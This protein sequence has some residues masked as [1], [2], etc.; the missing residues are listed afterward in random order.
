MTV[1]LSDKIPVTKRSGDQM[2]QNISEY[3]RGQEPME[4]LKKLVSID[5]RGPSGNEMDMIAFIMEYLK[6]EEGRYE[7]IPHGAN[8]G[9]MILTIPG[10][11]KEKIILL[12][13][14]DTVPSGDS[15]LWRHPPLSGH[16][17]GK[18]LYGSGAS[19]MKSG[20]AVLLITAGYLMKYGGNKKTVCLM[21][22]ADEECGCTG[23][24]AIR[25]GA[26]MDD[27]CMILVAEPTDG[28]IAVAEK[29]VMWIRISALGKQAHG[30]MPRQG[31]NA[32]EYLWES[33]SLLKSRIKN[34]NQSEGK[35]KTTLSTTVF[36]GGEKCNIIPGKANAIL[37]IRTVLEEDHNR[38]REY[39][40]DIAAKI[41]EE[42]G[43]EVMFDIINE[44]YPLRN[45][46]ITEP[47][48]NLMDCS[49]ESKTI[50][51]PYYTDLAELLK[52]RFTAFAV[53]GPGSI[54]Q[55]HKTNEWAEVD[56]IHTVTEQYL[57]YI[58][59]YC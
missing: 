7:I 5:T 3:I 35:A 24:K 40:K 29:G 22:T 56:K 8:R 33:I 44:K 4:L 54:E 59:D 19:D 57:N 6:P 53:L 51:I 23:A 20:L 45:P 39:L 21:L 11:E 31:L 1:K 36:H 32:N 47:V 30:A 10:Q 55:M 46:S 28:K 34:M 12:G 27:A 26:Y 41:Q 15:A 2:K 37:D 9:S 49:G 42:K 18:R 25:E 58:T 48:R 17:S 43:V 50:C 13:H 14:M 38:I 16:L 52:N